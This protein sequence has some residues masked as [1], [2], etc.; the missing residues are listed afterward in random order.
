MR[1]AG[2]TLT[3]YSGPVWGVGV[4]VLAVSVALLAL[5]RLLLSSADAAWNPDTS[6][7]PWS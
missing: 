3:G 7:D 5:G 2:A 1:R 6:L 4:A